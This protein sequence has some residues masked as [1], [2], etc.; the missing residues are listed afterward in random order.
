MLRDRLVWGVSNDQI[1]K[2]SLAEP[3]IK[4]QKAVG[5]AL[6]SES[7]SKNAGN[8]HMTKTNANSVKSAKYV[9]KVTHRKRTLSG[10]KNKKC[11]R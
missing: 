3:N 7:A 1:Q 5:L 6:A 9:D 8:L 4:Y 11:F 2:L 10:K